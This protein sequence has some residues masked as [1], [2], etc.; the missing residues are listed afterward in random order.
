MTTH[1][2]EWYER[3]KCPMGCG[4]IFTTELN[5]SVVCACTHSKIVSGIEHNLVPITPEDEPAFKHEAALSFGLQD[6]EVIIV[7]AGA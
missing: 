4:F 1:T 7:H 3:G 2:I 6:N 5:G